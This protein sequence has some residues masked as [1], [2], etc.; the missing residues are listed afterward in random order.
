[1]DYIR[2]P[3][4]LWL[5]GAISLVIAAVSSLIAA[6][7]IGL[8]VA[9]AFA[10]LGYPQDGVLEILLYTSIIWL[11]LGFGA[12]MGTVSKFLKG[13]RARDPRDKPK[14]ID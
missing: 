7:V 4:A 1:M 9:L 14:Q 3:L 13:Y 5:L 11:P 12:G 6:S 8:P 2:S 10:A